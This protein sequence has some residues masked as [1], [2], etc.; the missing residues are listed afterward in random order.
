MKEKSGAITWEEGEGRG[1][2]SPF[3]KNV[4]KAVTQS[5]DAGAGQQNPENEPRPE[6]EGL[7]GE[8]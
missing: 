8:I 4:K 7:K 5:S 2:Q 3:G 1:D 6:V